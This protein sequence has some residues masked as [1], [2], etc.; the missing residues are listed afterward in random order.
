MDSVLSKIRIEPQ[1]YKSKFP[2]S[3]GAQDKF[4]DEDF[5]KSLQREI[6][7]IK[8]EDWDRY[9]NPFEQKYTLRDKYNF[10]PFLV[11]LFQVSF[12]LTLLLKMIFV[13]HF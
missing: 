8:K 1:E 7:N 6:L 10:P 12:L 9:D 3:Y 5:A 2:Y 4:L 11:K 13:L